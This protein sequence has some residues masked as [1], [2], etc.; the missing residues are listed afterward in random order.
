MGRDRN[1]AMVFLNCE[2][3]PHMTVYQN[4]TFSHEMHKTPRDRIKAPVE[5]AARKTL[6]W[7]GAHSGECHWNDS[8]SSRTDR[9]C[10]HVPNK[11]EQM[12]RYYRNV[13]HGKRKKADVDDKIPCIV[14]PEL[15]DRDFRRNWARLI[16]IIYEVD[17]L[18]CPSALRKWG[19]LH[20]FMMKMW[21]EKFSS[22]WIFG[23][24]NENRSHAPMLIRLWRAPSI[25]G[26]PLYD[27]SPAPSADEYLTIPWQSGWSLFLRKTHPGCTS[28]PVRCACLRKETHRQAQTGD[29]CLKMSKMRHFMSIFLLIPQSP[30]RNLFRMLK[31]WCKW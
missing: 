7:P 10:S 28:L 1:I 16:Q 24:P 23:M 19:W 18:I 25:D 3:Y 26:F 27:K 5:E 12:V 6:T 22:T 14:E 9:V 2:L 13:A 15:T 4:M 20:S 8:G 17:H 31:F 21:S 29:L 30:L 11:G